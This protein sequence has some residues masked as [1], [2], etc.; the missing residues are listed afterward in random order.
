MEAKTTASPQSTQRKSSEIHRKAAKDAKNSKSKDERIHNQHARAQ[1]AA[2]MT[3]EAG[4][5]HPLFRPERETHP[6]IN[7]SVSVWRREQRQTAKALRLRSG[8]AQR[9]RRKALTAEHAEERRGRT[10]CPV[11]AG[12]RVYTQGIGRECEPFGPGRGG[13][14]VQHGDVAWGVHCPTYRCGVVNVY[15]P[16]ASEQR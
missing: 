1:R 11:P 15:H 8:Q 2:E 10:H 16:L 5:C 14:G 4:A 7:G 12:L 3:R 6:R 13:R 9:A